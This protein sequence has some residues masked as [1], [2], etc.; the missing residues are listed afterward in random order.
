MSGCL[1]RTDRTTL[2]RNSPTQQPFGAQYW[3]EQSLIGS[4]NDRHDAGL[5]HGNLYRRVMKQDDRSG[6]KHN[7][8]SQQIDPAMILNSD[9][10]YNK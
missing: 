1:H 4:K 5:N 8:S 6:L 2:P 3:M 7:S 9:C 10:I